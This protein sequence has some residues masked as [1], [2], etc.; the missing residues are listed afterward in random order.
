MQVDVE[1]E[2]HHALQLSV[3]QPCHILHVQLHYSL[4][5]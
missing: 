2:V 1:I 3:I 4:I 5:H